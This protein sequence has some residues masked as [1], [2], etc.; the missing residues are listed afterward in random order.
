[1]N[2]IEKLFVD[3]NKG[4]IRG[5]QAAVAKALN[6][7][8]ANIN[9]YAKKTVKPTQDTINAMC[10]LFKK[11][12]EELK[13]IFGIEKKYTSEVNLKK[14]IPLTDNNTISLPILA[15]VPAGLPEYS[16]KDVAYFTSI[17]RAL[18]PGADFVV[19]CIGD[20]LE[21]RILKG[22]FCVIRK[23][24][25]PLHGKPMLVKT[26][27]GFCMKVI[28]KEGKK[29]KL[30]SV[31]HGYKPFIP[32]ELEIVGLILGTW[33]RHDKDNWLHAEGK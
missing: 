12:E 26:E 10:T 6:T 16:D 32:K 14:V 5:S 8:T 18:F 33:S 1:M 25:E 17:P 22:D 4:K 7:S 28:C 11:T 15:G 30:C 29:I 19:E 21:P 2:E 13:S 20:S 3:Y 23:M 9:R 31:N 24:D 27:N